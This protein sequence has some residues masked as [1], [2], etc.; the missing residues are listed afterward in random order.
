FQFNP[1]LVNY[2]RF[3]SV[4]GEDWVSKNIR[5]YGL[6]RDALLDE[7]LNKKNDGVS[8][9]EWRKYVEDKLFKYAFAADLFN[10]RIKWEQG[11][12]N[13]ENE[14]KRLYDGIG[15]VK[16]NYIDIFLCVNG[17]RLK[18]INIKC[19]LYLCVLTLLGLKSKRGGAFF[20][21]KHS[22]KLFL[23][24]NLEVDNPQPASVISRFKSTLSSNIYEPIS[25]DKA[26]LFNDI[27]SQLRAMWRIVPQEE[28][29]K[30]EEAKVTNAVSY[31]N[32]S[33]DHYFDQKKY[34]KGV[35]NK[36]LK[37][38]KSFYEEIF[39]KMFPDV[40]DADQVLQIWWVAI[41]LGNKT[42][43]HNKEDLLDL[44]NGLRSQDD[45]L[46]SIDDKWCQAILNSEIAYDERYA[47][48]F[49]EYAGAEKWLQ[50]I[51]DTGFR[52]E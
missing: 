13:D 6:I 35:K 19:Y 23:Y 27:M 52:S 21:N 10:L 11:D 38:F 17:G 14:I 5:D 30:V 43:H 16:K 15:E 46:K 37:F 1:S 20:D 7:I 33:V 31:L 25:N 44:V 40:K 9:A 36:W 4:S 12:D 51:L 32:E 2:E 18:D 34:V 24:D 49:K 22:M 41:V 45:M 3:K 39:K 8:D 28:A 47:F 42:A 48:F 26:D 29:A 50:G